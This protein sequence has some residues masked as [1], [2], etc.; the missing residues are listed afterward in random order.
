M[1]T[2]PLID[3]LDRPLRDLRISVTD[4]CNFR[5]RYCMPAEFFDA[6]FPFLPQKE[7]LSFEEIERL[8][9]L[10]TQLG[11]EKIRITGGEP[12]L[13]KNLTT[14][15]RMLARVKGVQDLAMT[16]NGSLLS[17]FAQPLKNA[18]LKRVTV[19]LD[20]LD[21]Q[22]FMA[23]NDR[24]YTVEEVLE[25][26]DAAVHVGL[27]VKI[28]MVVQKGVNEDDIIPMA[29]FFKHKGLILRF[30]EY[31]D[32]GNTNGWKMEHVVSSAEIL[33]RINR[34]MPVEPIEANYYGE[35]AKRYKYKDD[36][37]EIGFISSVTQAFCA[38]CTR[39]RLSADGQLYP[40]L[41]SA[42]GYSLKE[43][44]RNGATDAELLQAIRSFWHKRDQRYSEER[45]K[46]TKKRKV[47][48]SRIGG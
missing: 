41:F 20:S 37:V 32:V 40:C 15:V 44:L 22:R 6:N 21:N 30:I 29:K 5:C 2:I 46:H 14:L 13:R 47:E 1:K 48:M 26:I 8:V 27:G 42:T 17:S 45:F 39:A 36:G 43:M 7:L 16:T 24:G 25:G 35:V 9:S 11:V 19:S 10:F 18:G 33:S 34:E 23:I 3:Q 38:S 31:M 12:L 28:N 4:K